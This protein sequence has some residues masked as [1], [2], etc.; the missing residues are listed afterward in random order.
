[1][2]TGTRR[3]FRSLPP[4]MRVGLILA[5]LGAA[6]DIGYHVG[7]GAAGAGHSAI[8]FTGHFVTLIGMVTTM[9]GLIGAA[10]VRRP[11]KSATQSK[12]EDR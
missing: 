10:L 12:G 5:T 9:V 3:T 2:L 7:A 11:V 6:I 1:M 8:A 4:L